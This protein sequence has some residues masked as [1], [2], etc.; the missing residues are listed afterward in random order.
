MVAEHGHGTGGRTRIPAYPPSS[1]RREPHHFV[2]LG[3][4]VTLILITTSAQHYAACFRN[5][6]DL[7]GAAVRGSTL[8]TSAAYTQDKY[9]CS[10]FH[11]CKRA[12]SLRNGSR[13]CG[14]GVCPLEGNGGA[15]T[16]RPWLPS[17]MRPSH[18]EGNLL[19]GRNICSVTNEVCPLWCRKGHVAALEKLATDGRRVPR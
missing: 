18:R 8:C 6:V 19:R 1:Q 14:N 17:T 7:Y 13:R 4:A 2:H 15:Q 11:F 9:C 3:Q 5:G 10:D 12:H 16:A